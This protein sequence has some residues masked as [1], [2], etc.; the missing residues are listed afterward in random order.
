MSQEILAPM[1][2]TIIEVLVKPGDSVSA[3]DELVI[4]ESMKMENPICAASDGTVKEVKVAVQD[5]VAAKQ[6]LVVLE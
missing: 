1:P 5:K 3:D 4:L 2:G 6:V